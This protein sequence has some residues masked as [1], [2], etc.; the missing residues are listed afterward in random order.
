MP[1][2]RPDPARQTAEQ[3]YA[4]LVAQARRPEFYAQLGV[5]D[6]LDG[7]FELLALHTF[8][9]LRRL[10]S[11]AD[12]ADIRQALVEVFVDD[13]DA[14]LREMGAGDLGIGRRV[15][16]MAQALYGRIA[17]YESGLAGSEQALIGALRRNL[18]GTAGEPGPD[19]AVVRKLAGYVR[20]ESAESAHIAES[21]RFGPPPSLDLSETEREQH[22]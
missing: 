4:A 20:R 11:K 13:M 22:R 8:L 5:P 1:W 18:F 9:A 6:T 2:L 19:P 14:S 17:A 7:R 15:K 3:L 12:A 21:F 16:A 10:K